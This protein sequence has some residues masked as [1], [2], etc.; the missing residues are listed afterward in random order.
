MASHDIGAASDRRVADR[1]CGARGETSSR[2]WPWWRC[3]D[4]LTEVALVKASSESVAQELR[5]RKKH[6]F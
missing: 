5:S 3:A 6:V 1:A 2:R 4:T